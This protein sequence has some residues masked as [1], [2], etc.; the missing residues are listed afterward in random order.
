MGQVCQWLDL[1]ESTS[2]NKSIII[3]YHLQSFEAALYKVGVWEEERKSI[4]DVLDG[5]E[6]TGCTEC[7]DHGHQP[8]VRVSKGGP[9]RTQGVLCSRLIV[10]VEGD[11]GNVGNTT[12]EEHGK[13]FIYLLICW[14]LD[15]D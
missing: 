6:T 11:N 14:M 12:I 7:I 5:F 2:W 13:K 10:L 8:A 3:D 4:H 9:R 15:K 1:L